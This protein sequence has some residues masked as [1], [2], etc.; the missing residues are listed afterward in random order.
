MDR[1][2]L[3]ILKAAGEILKREARDTPPGDNSAWF[4]LVNSASAM[5]APVIALENER[6]ERAPLP[7]VR[8]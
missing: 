1:N 8:R 4:V 5:L 2:D 6:Q 7:D 3:S